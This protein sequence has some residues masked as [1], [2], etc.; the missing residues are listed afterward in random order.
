LSGCTSVLPVEPA[1]QTV[2]EPAT[3]ALAYSNGTLPYHPLVYHLDL[4]VLSYHVY[5][6]SL[7]WPFD[8]YYEEL[9]NDRK[10]RS[11]YMELVKSWAEM[12][13]PAQVGAEAGLN[14]YRGPGVLSGFANNSLHDPILYNYSRIAPRHGAI[15]NANGEWT[16]YLTPKQITGRIGQTFVCY[17]KA[18]SVTSELA[19]AEV[20]PRAS[21]TAKDRTDILLAF[22]GG[23]G[24]KGEPGEPASQSLMGFA[25]LRQT[26]GENYDVHIA[27]RGSQAGS[28]GR[29]ILQAFNDSNSA[30][31]PDWITDLGYNRLTGGAS[32]AISTVG[33]L[34]RGFAMSTRSILP[35]LFHC[36][37]KG[38][39]LK[40]KDTGPDNIY[41][42]GHSLG[43][44]LAQ[45]FTSA[46]LLGNKYGPGGAEGRCR[47]R[48]ANGLGQA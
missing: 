48:C 21:E 36:L 5:G 4:S 45:N 7:V 27:F 46:V 13:G 31:N 14:A 1:P 30:G 16:E 19:F 43:G 37:E 47:N 29:A 6:Q 28:A 8:P 41:V 18:G 10:N 39:G 9:S 44:A 34:S 24:D 15:T 11:K 3:A 12:K 23:T 42:T 35:N 38:A 40:K 17:R 26:T 20:P 25:L 32:A 2:S 33:R 22:E